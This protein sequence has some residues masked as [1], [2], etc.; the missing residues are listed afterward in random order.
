MGSMNPKENDMKLIQAFQKRL[1]AIST[2]VC[3]CFLTAILAVP[4]GYS[5]DINALTISTFASGSWSMTT[6]SYYIGSEQFRAIDSTGM[7]LQDKD[8]VL[9]LQVLDGGG[10]TANT[11]TIATFSF[12]S[13][14][15]SGNLTASAFYGDGSNLTNLRFQDADGDTKIQVEESADEDFLRFDTAGS[16]RMVITATGSVGIGTPTPGKTLTVNGDAEVAGDF[17]YTGS[18]TGDGLGLS[19]VVFTSTNQTINGVKTFSSLPQL[20]ANPS[21]GDDAVRFSYLGTMSTQDANNVNIDG[22]TIDGATFGPTNTYQRRISIKSA[23]YQ[24]SAGDWI[25]VN[26]SSAPSAFRMTIPSSFIASDVVK[27]EDVGR[28]LLTTNAFIDP[29]AG[30]TINGASDSL[31]L[32]SNGIQVNCFATS[33]TNMN[34]NSR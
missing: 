29:G 3:F 8:G 11:G 25:G 26:T 27:F 31:M 5:A 21:A 13:A 7:L 12:T 16:E 6:D 4:T 2:A 19:N 10:F 14:Q 17:S 28:T 9:G 24:A 15:G 30:K 34:C 32:A 1:S 23:A 18:I 33:T 22:G 20:Q